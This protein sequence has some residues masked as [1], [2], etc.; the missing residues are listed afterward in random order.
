MTTLK[1][2]AEDYEGKQTA[3]I[4]DLESVSTDV[5]IRRETFKAGTPEEYTINIAS[6]EGIDYRVPD[7][8]LKSLQAILKAKPNLKTIKVIKTG[9]GMNTEYTIVPLEVQTELPSK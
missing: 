8:V 4:A 1:K 7:S 3:N 5:D 6:I 9:S 2:A